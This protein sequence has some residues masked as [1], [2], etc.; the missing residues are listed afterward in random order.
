MQLLGTL[1]KMIVL[2]LKTYGVWPKLYSEANL[3]VLP[4]TA[5]ERMNTH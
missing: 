3:Q 2:E 5:Q 1:M 4:K